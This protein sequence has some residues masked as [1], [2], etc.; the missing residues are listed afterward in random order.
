MVKKLDRA[1]DKVTA[2]IEVGG[3]TRRTSSTR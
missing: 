1:A 2:H 3:K